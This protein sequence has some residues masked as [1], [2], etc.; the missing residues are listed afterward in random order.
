MIT[1]ELLGKI[2]RMQAREKRSER[3]IA[4]RTGLSRNTVHKWLQS[5]QEVQVP[6]YVRAKGFNKLG[7]FTDELELALKADGYLGG[8]TRVTDFIRT[9]RASAGKDV[10]AFVPLKFDLGEAFQFDW[11][12]EG[13]VVGGIYDN[14]KTAVDKVKKGKGRT[15]NARFAVMCAHYLFDADFCNVCQRLGEGCGPE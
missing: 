7:D 11:S 5:A 14:M 6:K 12:E 13:M 15:V 3:A 9:W 2:R 8:Y 10:K 4:K 1:M